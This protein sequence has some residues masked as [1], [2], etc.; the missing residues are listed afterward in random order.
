MKKV[1]ALIAATA[2]LAATATPSF[3]WSFK[4]KNNGADSFNKIKFSQRSFSSFKQSNKSFVHNSVGIVTNTGGNEANKNTGDG[5]TTVKSGKATTNVTITNEGDTN[6]AIPDD[7]GCPDT[8]GDVVIKGNGD[9]SENKVEIHTSNS[10]W[11]SQSNFSVVHNS[12]GVSTNTGDNEANK[13]TGDGTN[14]VTSGNAETTVSIT[15]HGDTNIFGPAV[16]EE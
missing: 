13:N 16:V 3:A 5:D 7:C 15:N 6:V 14:S 4:I 1:I 12:V 10:S 11:Q 9:D 8:D 2:M